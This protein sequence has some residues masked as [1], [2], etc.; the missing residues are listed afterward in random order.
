MLAQPDGD[1]RWWRL[2]VKGLPRIKF[3]GRRLLDYGL[4]DN[5]V[6]AI[7]VVKTPLRVEVHVV[8]GIPA[9]EPIARPTNPVGIDAG[10]SSR[11]SLSDGEKI[12]ARAHDR[13]RA[14]RLQRRLGR[15]GRGSKS[16][17]KKRA[18]LAKEHRRQKEYRRDEDFRVVSGLVSAY[19]GFAVENLRIANMIKNPRLADK[20]AQQGWGNFNTRL[21]NKAERAGF[22]H[23]GT[24]PAHT[25]QTCSRCG[26][27]REPPLKLSERVFVCHACKL[28]L[29]RDENAAK[30]ICV[31]VFGSESGGAPPTCGA[32]QTSA[33]RPTTLSRHGETHADH[34]KQYAV[35]QTG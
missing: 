33:V 3:D 4:S 20:I 28:T 35:T 11:F 22:L 18:L 2:R 15:A 34:T 7:S 14:K 32:Q 23:G 16:R 29:D 24:N 10:I 19:D 8:L 12:P 26:T 25:S 13:T 1:G 17:E 30:Y 21:K 9:V 31:R 27:R 5:T 6:R